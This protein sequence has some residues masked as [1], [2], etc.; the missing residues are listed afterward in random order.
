MSETVGLLNLLKEKGSML[1][2]MVKVIGNGL[3]E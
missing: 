3:D 2:T 1:N